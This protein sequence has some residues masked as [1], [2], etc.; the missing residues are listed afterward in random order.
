MRDPDRFMYIAGAI[1]LIGIIV[2]IIIYFA[3]L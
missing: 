3:E 2:M 1:S